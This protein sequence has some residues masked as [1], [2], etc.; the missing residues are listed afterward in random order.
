MKTSVFYQ[1]KQHTHVSD[2][3]LVRL[4]YGRDNKHLKSISTCQS[5][6][7]LSYYTK[8][9]PLAFDDT[10]FSDVKH[11]TIPNLILQN[12]WKPSPWES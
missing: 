4:N 11:S 12:T 9:I 7:A 2:Q 6:S 10:S 3:T 5:E 1:Q 8:H